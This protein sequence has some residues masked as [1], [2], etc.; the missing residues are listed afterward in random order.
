VVRVLAQSFWNYAWVVFSA[1][2]QLQGFFPDLDVFQHR[3]GL[4]RLLL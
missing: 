4:R 2:T 1:Q 3:M